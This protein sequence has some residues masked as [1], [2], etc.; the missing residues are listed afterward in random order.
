MKLTYVALL[1]ASSLLASAV[2]PRY[3]ANVVPKNMSVQTKKERFYY[4]L[5][6]AV[7]KA[8]TELMKVYENVADD[9][10]NDNNKAMIAKLKTRYNVKTDNELLACLKP[11]P[12]SVT[13][14]QA[15]M[16]SSW[17]TSRFFV[18]ANN[19]FGM[20]SSNPNEPRIAAGEKRGGTK[21]I[22]LKKFDSVE[23]SV[24]AYYGLIAS[25][26]AFKEFRAV[27]LQ[28]NDPHKIIKTLDKYSEIGAEYGKELSQVMIH[29]R[30]V[31]YD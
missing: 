22:W 29:N 14:A 19:V 1:L 31:K 25:E 5:V 27:R 6:P 8:H 3:M 20:L 17:A 30:L 18:K 13:L 12:Q 28:T 24:K 2:T 16:E 15:A 11:H 7:K 23:A 4:L 26:K 21:T 10:K 9:I